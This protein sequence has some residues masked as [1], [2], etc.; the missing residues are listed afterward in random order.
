ML[1]RE[2]R[3]RVYLLSVYTPQKQ[4]RTPGKEPMEETP[5]HIIDLCKKEKVSA[6]NVIIIGNEGKLYPCMACNPVENY[7]L[8][9]RSEKPDDYFVVKGLLVVPRNGKVDT[10]QL[11]ALVDPRLEE[12][13]DKKDQKTIDDLFSS[14]LKA[15]ADKNAICLNVC[16]GL[17]GMTIDK[18]FMRELGI[19]HERFEDK[20]G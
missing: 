13:V 18:M 10:V 5:Q 11:I 14:A 16:T 12:T 17:T 9:I 8:Y 4:S 20:N 1:L 2:I 6:R 19:K 15:V 3:D 7:H